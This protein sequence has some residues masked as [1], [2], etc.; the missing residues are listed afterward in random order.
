MLTEHDV[1]FIENRERKIKEE[2][3]MWD[4]EELFEEV[5]VEEENDMNLLQNVEV[6]TKVVVS[7]PRTET[8]SEALF[9]HLFNHFELGEINDDGDFELNLAEVDSF[10]LE[11]NQEQLFVQDMQRLLRAI[12]EESGV[13]N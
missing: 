4:G 8:E 10:L 6:S 5:E 12:L 11:A 9:Q 2:N 13:V 1:E 3:D 7:F